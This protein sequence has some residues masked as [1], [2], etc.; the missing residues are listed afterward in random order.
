M[1]YYY[2]PKIY[3]RDLFL[4]VFFQITSSPMVIA[5]PENS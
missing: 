4:H 1:I 3:K 5:L 2:P